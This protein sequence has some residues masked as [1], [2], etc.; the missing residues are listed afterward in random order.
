MSKS[1]NIELKLCHCSTFNPQIREIQKI[2][3]KFIDVH[4][5]NTIFHSLN[6]IQISLIYLYHTWL[7]YVECRTHRH[8]HTHSNI[9]LFV[10][11]PSNKSILLFNYR[12]IMPLGDRSILQIAFPLLCVPLFVYGCCCFLVW[13]FSETLKCIH[14]F[15]P[16]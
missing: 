4:S 11:A 7:R 1:S 2:T 15:F 14:S 6:M 3:W 13:L 9:Y 5:I 10:Y 16:T 8:T 12:N